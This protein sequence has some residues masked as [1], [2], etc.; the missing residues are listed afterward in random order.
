MHD[1]RPNKKIV[2]SAFTLIELL[3]V[4]AII[5]VLASL[6]LPAL[7]RAKQLA[8]GAVCLNNLKQ[9]GIATH[10]YVADN[11]DLL[12]QDG[13][14]YPSDSATNAGWYIDL[15]RQM[16]LPRY[17]DMAWRTNAAAE[18]GRVVWLC[19]SNK[20]RSDGQNLFH[21]CLNEHVNGKGTGN[22]AP[23]SSFANPTTLVWLFD[24]KNL[25]ACGGA[26][27]V[28]TNLHRNGSQI[29]FL[30]SHAA[31]LPS[32]V[33]WNFKTNKPITNSADVVWYP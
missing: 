18:P 14:F 31:R 28:H 7:A 20:R 3:V 19:P 4:I 6:I 29:L 5:S 21:Y 17:H 27:F 10:L 33:Y 24:S 30:D 16:N 26:S 15:P 32:R 13:S 22:Q 9:W 8:N 25:P 1:R 23:L 12:P 2:T 11:D